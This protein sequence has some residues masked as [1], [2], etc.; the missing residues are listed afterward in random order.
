M[1]TVIVPLDFSQTSLN[2]AHYAANMFKNRQ[3]IRLVLYHFYT[4]GEDAEAARRYL[5]S[6]AEELLTS[7]RNIETVLESGDNFINRLSAFAHVKRAELIV[8]GLTG[9]TPKEQRFSGSNTLRMSEREIC[10]VL[11]I[12][13][14]ASFK[15][16]SNVMISSELRSVEETP[17]LMAVKRVLRDFK[18][19]V[20]ILHVDSNVY[21][22]LPPA[23]QEQRDKM[24]S[25]LSEFNPEFYFMR[26]FDFHDSIENFARDKDIDMIVIA[27]KFH[28]LY[29]RLFKTQ[30][31]KKLVY[32]SSV[33]ILTVHE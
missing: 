30:H 18:P 8:M 25:L 7:V 10:P 11:I 29:A 16:I 22:S 27:P 33:P 5:T 2:A 20:H 4:S 32:Q 15:G 26:L 12:P 13:E 21:V 31:T 14:N 6:L 28:G 9:K 17:S 1:H 24:H 3:D 19:A 23:L